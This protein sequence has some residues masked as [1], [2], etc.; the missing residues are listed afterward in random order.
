MCWCLVLSQVKWPARFRIIYKGLVS[1]SQT[2]SLWWNVCSVTKTT[3]LWCPNRKHLTT[4]SHSN[5]N[6]AC[7]LTRREIH[8]HFQTWMAPSMTHFYTETVYNYT[9]WY[10]TQLVGRGTETSSDLKT[11]SLCT[12]LQIMSNATSCS[13]MEWKITVACDMLQTGTFSKFKID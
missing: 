12:I 5:R 11:T 9:T 7:V 8:T 1:S 10:N 4:C 2:R 6:H 3:H 13:I